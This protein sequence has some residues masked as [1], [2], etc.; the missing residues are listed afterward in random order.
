V[1]LPAPEDVLV[2]PE[3]AETSTA[4]TETEETAMSD[5]VPLP[6]SLQATYITRAEIARLRRAEARRKANQTPVSDRDH[7]DHPDQLE[8]EETDRA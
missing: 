3:V 2:L 1:P 7:H 4:E 8:L 6:Y 5:V